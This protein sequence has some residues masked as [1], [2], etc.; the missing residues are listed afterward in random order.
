MK[1]SD[2]LKDIRGAQSSPEDEMKR[3]V[4]SLA[5]DLRLDTGH[6]LPMRVLRK[7]TINFNPKEQ[8]AL[9]RAIDALIEEG[10][11]EKRDGKPFLTD[12]GKNV[13]Y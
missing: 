2:A 3:Y 10:V 1:I 11:F 9:A 6:V 7:K 12:R 13:L 8:E 5:K 4:L